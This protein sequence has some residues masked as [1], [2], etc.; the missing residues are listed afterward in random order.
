MGR[1]KTYV[2][3]YTRNARFYLLNG[4]VSFFTMSAF[5][6]LLGIYFKEKHYAESFVGMILSM[7]MVAMGIGSIPSAWLLNRIGSKKSFIGSLL[8]IA[9]GGLGQAGTNQEILV[10][11]FAIL[12]GF[13]FSVQFT[14]E[15]PFLTD[16]ST[17]MERMSL[18]SLN[19]VLKNIAMM[20]GNF[21]TGYVSDYLKLFMDNAKATQLILIGCSLLALTGIY[22][23]LK[24]EESTVASYEG[25]DLLSDFK[26]MM[27]QP[28]VV[29]Y[30]V[31]NALIGLGAGMVVPFFSVYLKYSLHIDDGVVGGILSFSQ[32]GTVIGGMLIPLLVKKLGKPQVV[33]LCQI[34][35]IPFLLSIAFP[36][37]LILVT[38][39]FFMRSS[40][41]NM[42]QPVLQ[43]LSMNLVEKDCRAA[44][45]SFLALSNNILRGVGVFLGGML[46]ERFTYHTPYYFTVFMYFVGTILFMMVFMRDALW[47]T[48]G[49][50]E[51]HKIM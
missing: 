18:F 51:K 27:C 2:N 7:Q 28:V 43:E 29:L 30:L 15:P 34:L 38:L 1:L 40:L 26:K 23:L 4:F 20:L 47:K 39:S 50:F 25:S 48:K 16:N 14:G 33:V 12:Y 46:M 22:P 49:Y 32:L 37:G 3:R 9:I 6:I 21:A 35:S 44:F 8:L 17:P 19:F 31:Y 36:Q 41:M 42:A 45:S 10:V 5:S 24:I 11:F 13:G